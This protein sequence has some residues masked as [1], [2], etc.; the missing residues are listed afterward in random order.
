MQT[1][2]ELYATIDYAGYE[3]LDESIVTTIVPVAMAQRS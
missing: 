1:R 3:A 2:A